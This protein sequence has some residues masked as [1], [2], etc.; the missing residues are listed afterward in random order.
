MISG[1]ILWLLALGVFFYF[2]VRSSGGCCGGNDHEHNG[3]DDHAHQRSAMV[4]QNDNFAAT[5]GSPR[6]PACGMTVAGGDSPTSEHGGRT[7]RFCSEQCRK[8]F[9]LNPAKFAE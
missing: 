4:E 7:F 9:D 8:L 1:G 5:A 3:H 6:D 2:M